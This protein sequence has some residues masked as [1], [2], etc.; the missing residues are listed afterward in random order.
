MLHF[1]TFFLVKWLHFA[2]LAIGGGAMVVALLLSGLEEEREDLRGLA[3]GVWRKVVVWPIRFAVALG[4]L[5]LL[6]QYRAG[7]PNPLG[8]RYLHIKLVLALLLV[9]FSEMTPRALAAGKRGAALLALLFFLLASFVAINGS[10]F[11]RKAKPRP[12]VQAP[13]FAP[14]VQAS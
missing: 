6:I 3:A 5:L 2:A 10:A 4:A 12:E 7:D 8:P 11:P 9:A 14:D 1:E 13:E